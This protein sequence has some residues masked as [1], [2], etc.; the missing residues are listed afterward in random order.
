MKEKGE[1]SFQKE[2][3]TL[4]SKILPQSVYEKEWEEAFREA[5]LLVQEPASHAHSEAD[6]QSVSPKGN[7]QNEPLTT[8]PSDNPFPNSSLH[9]PFSLPSISESNGP[10]SAS[11]TAVHSLKQKQSN[12]TIGTNY[13]QQK[14]KKKQVPQSQD[15]RPPFNE[16]EKL[17]SEV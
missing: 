5:D 17:K 10:S 11:Q 12:N 4:Q 14:Q 3:D 1:S 8:F 9:S 6:M 13:K 15:T 7:N 2:K 16:E